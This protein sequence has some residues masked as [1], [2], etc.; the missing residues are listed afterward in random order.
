MGG[1]GAPFR[2][3]AGVFS[4]RR[5]EENMREGQKVMD[6]RE[7]RRPVGKQG[8][9]TARNFVWEGAV[10]EENRQRWEEGKRGRR[11]EGK[12]G[13]GEEGKADARRGRAKKI[14]ALG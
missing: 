6:V 4:C 13:R 10:G 1:V 8:E 3:G 11:E 12:R 2:V 5:H 9:M 14:W 7:A